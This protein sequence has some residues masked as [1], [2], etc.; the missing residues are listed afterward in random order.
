MSKPV[1]IA[2][3]AATVA[4]A[5]PVASW[6]T[7][8]QIQTVLD[9]QYAQV[10]SHPL[11]GVV[12]RDYQRGIFSAQ[13][14]VTI[15]INVP[16]TAD[17][18]GVPQVSEPLRLTVNNQ[19]QHGPFPGFKRF[20]AATVDSDLA[21]DELVTEKLNDVLGGKKPLEGHTVYRYDG[22]GSAVVSSPAFDVSLP[23]G[24]GG[25]ARVS[26]SGFQADIDF[27]RN[28]ATYV[29][30]G[31]SAGLTV[32][33]ASLQ[34]SIAG[35][36]F[37]ADQRRLFEDDPFLFSGKQR[38]TADS[39]TG[40]TPVG[41]D[42][43]GGK[44]TLEKIVYDVDVPANGDFVDLIARV[45]TEVA[46]FD[47]VDYGPIHYDFSLKHLHA[48]TLSKLYQAFIDMSADPELL[49]Q[50]AEDPT[51]MLLPL[52]EPAMELL[53]HN[54]EFSFDRVSFRSP[55][56]QSDISAQAR[57]NGLQPD[58]VSSPFMLLAKLEVNGTFS[59]P[60]GLLEF[61]AVSRAESDEEAD[62]LAEQLDQQIEMFAANGYLERDGDLVKSSVAYKKG[63]LTVNG[64]PFN[65]LALG[66]E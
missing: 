62:F 54:P 39:V 60:Q 14:T 13:E 4:L 7:G 21:F 6:F 2:L 26:F 20:A 31:Q 33:D 42:G 23:N 3:V 46:R 49:A 1:K 28:M 53:G 44:V 64:K 43:E 17:E 58:E 48:R 36:A 41:E 51:A 8:K 59:L 66:A 32:E 11:M 25:V 38:F 52:S 10:L 63:E 55:Y 61:F 29:M 12:K 65:P 15:E 56:G 40:E 5:Y 24:E 34:L 22:S 19:I 16:T 47:D 30:K 57:L 9:E 50:Q 27:T 45:G 18:N 35:L 37:E